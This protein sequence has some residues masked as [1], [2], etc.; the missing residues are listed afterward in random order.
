[1]K[2]GRTLEQIQAAHMTLDY[3]GLYATPEYTGAMFV[4]AIYKDL[5]RTASSAR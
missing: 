5:Q 1:M 3:D 2:A 4:E